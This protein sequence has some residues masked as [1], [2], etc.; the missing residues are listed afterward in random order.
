MIQLHIMLWLIKIYIIYSFIRKM[1]NIAIISNTKH[2]V[3][4]SY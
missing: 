2:S 1:L 3:N 4:L